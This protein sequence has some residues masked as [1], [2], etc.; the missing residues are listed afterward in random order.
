MRSHR[1]ADDD[2][3]TTVIF[4]VPCRS[5]A[6]C[7]YSHTA[8]S[9]YGGSTLIPT[10]PGTFPASGQVTEGKVRRSWFGVE[11]SA[12]SPDRLLHAQYSLRQADAMGRARAT[13]SGYS[14]D[15]QEDAQPL[16]VSDRSV[17]VLKV[18][19]QF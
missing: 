1:V 6:K 7:L 11:Q 9:A 2:A 15:F 12:N 3:E 17:V 8:Y 19:D 10:N 14:Y 5:G 16:P 13:P 18:R 4:G